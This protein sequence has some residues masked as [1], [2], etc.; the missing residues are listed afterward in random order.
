VDAII[1]VNVATD[2][3]QTVDA[4]DL[5]LALGVGRIFAAWITGRI[6]EYGFEQGK[7]FEVSSRSGNNPQGGRPAI[8]YSLS[9]A[10]AK[11]LAMLE[12]NELGRKVR[13]YLIRV[14]EQWHRPEAIMARALQ[15]ADTIIRDMRPKAE[16]HDRLSAANGDVC[17]TDAGRVLG[18]KPRLLLEQMGEAGILFRGSHG[19]WEPAHE[20]RERGYFRVR[21]TEVDGEVYTQTLVTPKGVQWLAARYPATDKPGSLSLVKAS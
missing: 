4:R 20:Y 15:V 12:N 14:E 11:E 17:L 1:P 3:R 9:V 16:A 13:Q 21:V 2:G 6:A 19:R 7:D 18:R 5:H 8:E 10:M